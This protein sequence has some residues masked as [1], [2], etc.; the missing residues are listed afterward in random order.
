VQVIGIAVLDRQDDA[1]AFARSHD[2]TYPI[3]FD[4]NG[5]AGA[6]YRVQQLPLHVFI[7]ADGRVKQ[8]VP[9]G[10]IP[11]SELRAGLS[12]ITP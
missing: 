7:G 11:A 10:P 12:Q 8:Y 1:V 4:K 2:L 5:S 6:V 3:A 9:G